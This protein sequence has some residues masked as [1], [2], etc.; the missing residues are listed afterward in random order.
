MK[1]LDEGISTHNVIKTDETIKLTLDGKTKVY[2]VYRIK[3]DW[4]FYNDRND[5]IATFISEY[6]N[7]NGTGPDLSNLSQ[8]NDTIEKFIVNSD[9]EKLNQTKTNIKAVEQRIAG[10]VLNDG[11]VIDGNRRFTCLRQL[12]KEEGERFNY[13]NAAILDRN[14]ETD[15]KQIKMLELM[16]QHGEDKKVDYNPVDKLVGIYNDVIKTKLLDEK[17]Y[18]ESI[19]VTKAE[20]EKMIEEAQRLEDFLEFI[21]APEKFYLAREMKVHGVLVELTPNLKKCK[22]P[23]MKQALEHTIYTQLA[24]QEEGDRVRSLRKIY[25]IV[26]DDEFGEPFLKEQNQY[27]EKFLKSLPDEV[28][29]SNIAEIRV[30]NSETL[31]KINESIELN[32]KKVEIRTLRTEPY[33]LVQ[34][35]KGTILQ[36]DIDVINTLDETNRQELKN[37]LD[38]LTKLI[39]Q[40]K[41]NIK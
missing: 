30:N 23:K 37:A 8:Y 38:A 24:L 34:E 25:K 29:E 12:Y 22:T 27:I 4:L 3:L 14:I 1:L 32:K 7:T 28:S 16:L 33:K 2:P 41:G 11:R 9:E 6:I 5:R 26:H 18:R 15:A 17:E 31:N 35:A 36:L 13:F 40:T 10:V 21:N 39:T 20:M 19:N